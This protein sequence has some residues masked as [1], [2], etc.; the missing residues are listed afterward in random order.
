MLL[1]RDVSGEVVAAGEEGV[2]AKLERESRW[3]RI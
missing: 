3:G 2:G 1:L